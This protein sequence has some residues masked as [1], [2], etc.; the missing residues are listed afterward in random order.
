MSCQTQSGL[1]LFSVFIFLNPNKLKIVGGGLGTAGDALICLVSE[2]G[3]LHVLLRG[4][5]DM[6][7]LLSALLAK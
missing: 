6:A 7:D 2:L 4:D 3:E 5:I 1:T